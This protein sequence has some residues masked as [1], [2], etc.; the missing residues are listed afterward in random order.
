MQEG[1]GIAPQDYAVYKE[2][3]NASLIVTRY[4][5][6]DEVHDAAEHTSTCCSSSFYGLLSPVSDLQASSAM[7]G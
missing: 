7:A 5:T 1:A 2:L 6:A 3:M 4:L